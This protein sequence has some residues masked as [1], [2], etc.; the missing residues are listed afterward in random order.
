MSAF[1]Q[2]LDERDTPLGSALRI[3]V[4]RQDEMAMSW[5]EVWDCFSDSYPGKW[6]LQIF[7][8]ESELMDEVNVYHLFV[9]DHLPACF[10]LNYFRW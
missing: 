7:P 3:K 1:I 9:Y 4:R 2:E 6:A 8:P 10:N 5:R